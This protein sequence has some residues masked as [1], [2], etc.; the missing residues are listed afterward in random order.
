MDDE[1]YDLVMDVKLRWR[2]VKLYLQFESMNKI[3]FEA[4]P[5]DL[6]SESL[7]WYFWLTVPMKR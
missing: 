7:D 5:R 2:I 1:H 4:R 3:R 6:N